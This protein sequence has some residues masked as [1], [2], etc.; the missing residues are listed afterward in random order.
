MQR[1]V[2]SGCHS[3]S[4]PWCLKCFTNEL[5]ITGL[6]V[7]MGKHRYRKAGIASNLL[8]SLLDLGSVFRSSVACSQPVLCH[9][10]VVPLGQ[11]RV[12]KTVM[13]TS[14]D[15]GDLSL[16]TVLLDKLTTCK[17]HGEKN[18]IEL[19]SPKLNP[20]VF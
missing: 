1:R 7:R 12:Q 17:M 13:Q 10:T 16:C 15:N 5:N 19:L 18:A 20:L 8:G 14:P 4:H 6:T 11:S 3:V 2:V 9:Y